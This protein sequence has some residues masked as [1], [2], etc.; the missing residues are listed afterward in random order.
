MEQKKIQFS[1]S[2]ASTIKHKRNPSSTFINEN[3]TSVR[4]Q[5]QFYITNI[6][7][8]S[9]LEKPITNSSKKII[10]LQSSD[11][12]KIPLKNRSISNPNSISSPRPNTTSQSDPKYGLLVPINETNPNETAYRKTMQRSQPLLRAS[13]ATYSSHNTTIEDYEEMPVSDFGA[14]MLRGM[15]WDPE[16]AQESTTPC[17]KKRPGFLGLGAN[18]G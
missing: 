9:D 18:P 12:G 13:K 11:G 2:T 14:A 5:A 6:S 8:I 15:G 4:D 3:N 16:N 1:L 10:P 17:Q 7:N